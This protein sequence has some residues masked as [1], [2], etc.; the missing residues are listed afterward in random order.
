MIIYL[1]LWQILTIKLIL[2]ELELEFIWILQFNW[3]FGS[4]TNGLPQ[5]GLPFSLVDAWFYSFRNQGD[6]LSRL[7]LFDCD[8]LFYSQLRQKVF[9]LNSVCFIS[10]G[11][12]G[13]SYAVLLFSRQRWECLYFDWS[14]S[15]RI[16]RFRQLK[17]R[18]EFSVW[19][20]IWW[21]FIG[22]GTD[23]GDLTRFISRGIRIRR[24]AG[25]VCT[26]WQISSR[27]F[28]FKVGSGVTRRIEGRGVVGSWIQ[29]GHV[30]GRLY[31]VDWLIFGLACRRADWLQLFRLEWSWDRLLFYLFCWCLLYN[32]GAFSFLIAILGIE[33]ELIFNF[34]CFYIDFERFADVFEIISLL[35][36]LFV[37]GDLCCSL[38]TFDVKSVSKIMKLIVRVSLF[39]DEGCLSLNRP[40]FELLVL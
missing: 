12:I 37:R 38:R 25:R 14:R 21:F 11:L 31:L 30:A 39:F 20:S 4:Q 10:F 23:E 27:R 8:T 28:V 32:F 34:C 2:S 16:L 22:L 15:R 6:Y 13:R 35:T 36:V 7:L 19:R 24:R 40:L 17:G 29:R 18:D 26:S 1:Y 9:L 5:R 3:F 33:R